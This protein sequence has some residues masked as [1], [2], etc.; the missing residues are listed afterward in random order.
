MPVLGSSSTSSSGVTKRGIIIPEGSLDVWRA[1]RATHA[2]QRV[3]AVIVGDSTWWGQVSAGDTNPG[4]NFYDVDNYSPV[5]KIRELSLAAGYT[6]GGP[7]IVGLFDS[8]GSLGTPADPVDRG[9]TATQAGSVTTLLSTYSPALG[10]TQ[11]VTYRPTTS[12]VRLWYWA[13]GDSGSFTYSVNGAAAVTV[14]PGT[15]LAWGSTVI[16]GFT[17]GVTTNT[18]VLTNVT[19]NNRVDVE[20]LNATGLVFHKNCVPGAQYANFVTSADETGGNNLLLQATLGA[21]Q[22]GAASAAGEGTH[23]NARRVRLAIWT[24]GVNDINAVAGQTAPRNAESFLQAANLFIQ[25]A[26]NAG[27]DPVICI[28]HWKVTTTYFSKAGAMMASGLASL[29]AANGV[30]LVDM[31]EAL[32]GPLSKWSSTYYSSGDPHLKKVGYQQLG[33]WLWSN[34]INA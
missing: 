10:A 26:R 2:S 12:Q 28:P 20:F 14:T 8:A 23:P 27:A 13:S 16:S 24:L 22:V 15:T 5:A 19:G 11:T 33:S 6:D 4:S 21:T 7:G 32:G 17:A 31:N 9:Y 3:E 30:A 25:V 18:L 29:A 1:A 34:L